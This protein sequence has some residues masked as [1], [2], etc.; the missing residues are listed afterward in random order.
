MRVLILIPAVYVA[1]VLETSLAD[2]IRVGPIVPDL[3]ALV[4]IAWLLVAPGPRSFLAAGVVGL[5]SDLISPGH[6]GMAAASFLLVGYGVTRL[7]ARWAITHF[8]VQVALV[9]AAVTVIA[10]ALAMGEWLMGTA[11]GG[12][13]LLLSR[14]AGVGLYTAGVSLPMLMVVGWMQEPNHPR[15]NPRIAGG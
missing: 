1:A 9:F 11:P 10:S 2:V 14:S 6:V 4:A 15:N 5:A 3:L 8:V 13:S 7:R 12:P